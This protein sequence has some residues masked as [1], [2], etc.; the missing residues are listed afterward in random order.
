MTVSVSKISCFKQ[1]KYKYNLA[2]IKKV[3]QERFDFFKKGSS[4]HKMFEDFK[5][6]DLKNE[7]EVAKFFKS[8][9]GKKHL[10]EI[11][12]SQREVRIGLKVQE[13]KVVP[14]DYSD[15]DAFFHGIIDVLY[16][17]TILDYKT[18]SRKSFKDQDWTQLMYYAVWLFLNS[19]YKEVNISYMY[20]EHNHENALTLKRE[21][22]N[23]ILKKMLENVIEITKFEGE[24]T[25][26]H[27][28]SWACEYC[29]CKGSCKFY[30]EYQDSKLEN[31][32]FETVV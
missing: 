14:C 10:L 13:G 28:C 2:Y 6:E 7:S 5:V 1:C 25:E 23:A 17:N 15:P 19:D 20:V 24:P 29:T 4:I 8:E 11:I 9:V 3:E 21:H 22:L 30:K 18:G 27:T 31:I 26:E 16:N 12:Y 32:E